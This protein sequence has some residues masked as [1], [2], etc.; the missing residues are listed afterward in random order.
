M[1]KSK[2]VFTTLLAL[3]FSFVAGG[4]SYELSIRHL[5]GTPDPT[6]KIL[7]KL[8]FIFTGDAGKIPLRAVDDVW[9]AE[10]VVN[11]ILTANFLIDT[12]ATN[13]LVSPRIAEAFQL[14]RERTILVETI[15]GQTQGYAS[16]IAHLQIGNIELKNFPVIVLGL[17]HSFDGVLGQNFLREFK[18]TVDP[19][20]PAHM[21]LEDIH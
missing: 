3:A 15:G 4:W 5:S 19:R 17:W 2:L 21:R 11:K 10:V 9:I 20:E 18:I 14:V 16:R 13:T 12:G 1:S 7:Q 8:E 6:R